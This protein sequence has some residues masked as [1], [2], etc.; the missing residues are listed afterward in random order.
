MLKPRHGGVFYWV[1][2]SRLWLNPCAGA[3]PRKGLALLACAPMVR[4]LRLFAA[5]LVRIVYAPLLAPPFIFFV[6]A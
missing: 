3:L 4:Y 6:A 5:P 1:K 2:P